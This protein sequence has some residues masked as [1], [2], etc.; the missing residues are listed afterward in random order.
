MK[1]R[2]GMLL[3]IVVGICLSAMPSGSY[4]CAAAP[5]PRTP[6]N[7]TRIFT[8][9]DGQT[10][11]EGVEVKLMPGPLAGLDQSE[12]AKVSSCY[13]V[14]VGPGYV[15]D[16]H[17]ASARRYVITLSGHA[18]IELKDGRK[19]RLGPGRVLQAEDLTG[20][21]HIFRAIGTEDWTAAFVQLGE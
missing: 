12:S 9:P 14:R 7:L 6:I 2:G 10:H 3:L 13:F 18:E 20:K 4:V 17:N 1:T 8:G 5:E 21:G 19:I 11:E 15:E 16:W